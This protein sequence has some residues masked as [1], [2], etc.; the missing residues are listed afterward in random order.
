MEVLRAR[1]LQI[2]EGTTVQ[3]LSPTEKNCKTSNIPLVLQE[4]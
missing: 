3:Y 4:V 2:Y 1:L